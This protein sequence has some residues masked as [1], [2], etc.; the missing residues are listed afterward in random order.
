MFKNNKQKAI[1]LGDYDFLLEQLDR[2][3]KISKLCKSEYTVKFYRKLET[4]D[5]IIF[6]LECCEDNLNNYLLENGELKGKAFKN[7]I[8]S[9]AK[10]LKTLHDKGVMHR[11]IKQVIFFIMIQEKL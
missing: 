10:A 6:E 11:D 7:I 4:K 8:I 2:E 1:Q 3:E 9:L 5:N